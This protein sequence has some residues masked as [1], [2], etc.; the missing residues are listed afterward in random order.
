ML[1]AHDKIPTSWLYGVVKEDDGAAA[2]EEAERE[3][4]MRAPKIASLFLTPA[5]EDAYK[6]PLQ[7]KRIRIAIKRLRAAITV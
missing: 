4:L 1:L 7:A 3:A 6:S 2:R 5:H